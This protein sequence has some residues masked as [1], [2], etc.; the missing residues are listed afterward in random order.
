MSHY[1]VNRDSAKVPHPTFKTKGICQSKGKLT[2]EIRILVSSLL[3]H[4]SIILYLDI[5]E[6]YASPIL[7]KTGQ[8]FFTLKTCK[9]KF[10]AVV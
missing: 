8:C 3:A 9:L 1:S 7:K 4:V 10:S 2:D 5:V 6:K